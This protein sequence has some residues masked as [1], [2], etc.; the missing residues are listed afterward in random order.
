MLA[1]RNP[2]WHE[3]AIYMSKNEKYSLLPLCY[4]SCRAN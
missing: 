3:S 2:A 1:I 4:K